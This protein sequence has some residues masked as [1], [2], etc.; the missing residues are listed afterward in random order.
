MVMGG[1]VVS[2]MGFFGSSV[3]ERMSAGRRARAS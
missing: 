1:G 2:G 3:V